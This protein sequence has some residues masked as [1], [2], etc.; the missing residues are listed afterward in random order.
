MIFDEP[1]ANLDP[2]N[3]KIIAQQIKKLQKHHQVILITHDLHLACYFE[4]D[5]AFIKEQKLTLYTK[6]FFND[7]TLS[8]LYNVTFKSLVAQY[9]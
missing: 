8:E 4:A 6:D 9:E 5:V 7:T 3:T 1:T 2:H